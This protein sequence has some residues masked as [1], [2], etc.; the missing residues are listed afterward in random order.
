MVEGG[1]NERG[2]SKVLANGLDDCIAP[3]AIP[4]WTIRKSRFL[5]LHKLTDAQAVEQQDGRVIRTCKI[6]LTSH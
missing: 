1:D 5:T 2:R 3:I 6:H 4:D